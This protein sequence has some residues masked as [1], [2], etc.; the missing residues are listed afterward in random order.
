MIYKPFSGFILPVFLK[1]LKH[2]LAFCWHNCVMELFLLFCLLLVLICWYGLVLRLKSCAVSRY[3]C[4][5]DPLLT[6]LLLHPSPRHRYRTCVCFLL[7]SCSIQPVY[8]YSLSSNQLVQ[9]P[10]CSIVFSWQVI[11]DPWGFF[12]Q[13]QAITNHTSLQCCGCCAKFCWSQ[14]S[15][16][17]L[18][19]FCF[20]FWR[21]KT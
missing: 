14:R 20:C 2:S 3:D 16:F 9:N 4:I 5:S 8:S 10:P 21:F 19:Y 17:A 1:R 11:N 13:L 6:V 15:F 18:T 7:S 12:C